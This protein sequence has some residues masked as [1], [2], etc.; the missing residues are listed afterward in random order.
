[1]AYSLGAVLSILLFIGSIAALLVSVGS[2]TRDLWALPLLY[3]LRRREVF[4]IGIVVG[5]V[6][7]SGT[8]WTFG[9]RHPTVPLFVLLAVGPWITVKLT[10]LFAWYTDASETRAAALEVR[11]AEAL[12]LDETLPTIGQRWPWASYLCDVERARRRTR[13]EPPPI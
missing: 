5:S 2:F 6:I 1:M 10:R 11:V 13:Y 7:F 12:R 3:E 9:L 8:L 4:W